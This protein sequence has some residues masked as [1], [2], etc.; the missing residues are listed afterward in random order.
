MKIWCETE[1]KT[2][3]F[4]SNTG[5]FHLL[6]PINSPRK[7]SSQ[8]MATCDKGVTST[9]HF[10]LKRSQGKRLGN[11]TLLYPEAWKRAEETNKLHTPGTNPVLPALKFITHEVQI[12]PNI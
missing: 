6:E 8:L 10:N 11:T 12:K 1:M 4:L 2:E 5:H 9:H 3:L 7:K